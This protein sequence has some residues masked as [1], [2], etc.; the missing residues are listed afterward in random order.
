MEIK[1]DEQN[2]TRCFNGSD[3]HWQNPDQDFC[4]SNYTIWIY[5][6]YDNNLLGKNYLPSGRTNQSSSTGSLKFRYTNT[7]GRCTIYLTFLKT[8]DISKYKFAF[9]AGFSRDDTSSSQSMYANSSIT[10][11]KKALKENSCQYFGMSQLNTTNNTVT[12]KRV[13]SDIYILTPSTTYGQS[14]PQY[15]T[16]RVDAKF[17]YSNDYHY[18]TGNPPNYYERWDY[19]SNTNATYGPE[20]T[21]TWDISSFTYKITPGTLSKQPCLSGYIANTDRIVATYKGIQYSMFP[22]LKFLCNDTQEYPKDSSGRQINYIY[23]INWEN[24]WGG[25]AAISLH[26]YNI[27][28]LPEG[29]IKPNRKYVYIL[30]STVFP[31]T[32]YSYVYF[33]DPSNPEEPSTR[34]FTRNE[35]MK[36]DFDI[37]ELDMDEPLPFELTEIPDE[38]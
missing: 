10:H 37:I 7:N 22:P 36:P 2:D 13:N 21:L 38:I 29:G 24:D 16:N 11:Y 8:E 32:I 9:A 31:N 5:S 12:L 27:L 33:A 30:N 35:D 23:L 4:S 17:G 1:T 25:A 20:F 19:T 6:Y 28:P 26:R 14:Y 34:M 15:T 18:F 3:Y